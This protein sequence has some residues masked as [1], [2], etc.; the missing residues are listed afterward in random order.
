MIF[1]KKSC[2]HD[3]V[4]EYGASEAGKTYDGDQATK[5][6]RLTKSQANDI[7]KMYTVNSIDF[8]CVTHNTSL[9]DVL[10]NAHKNRKATVNKLLKK[11]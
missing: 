2:S 9:H 11:P 1:V 7:Y 5:W 10:H 6:Y 4:E 8:N 3:K